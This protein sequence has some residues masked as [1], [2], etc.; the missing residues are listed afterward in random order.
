MLIL[1]NLNFKNKNLKNLC[2]VY[3]LK[4]YSQNNKCELLCKLNE[5]KA[6]IYIQQFFRKKKYEEY[7]CPITLDKLKYPFISI[8]KSNNSFC[9]YSLE[10]FVEYLNKSNNLIDPISRELLSD[11]TISN[12]EYLVKH[13][14]IKKKFNNRSWKKKIDLRAEYLTLTSCLNDVFNQIFSLDDLTL[15]FIYED[16]I[17]Q[18]IYYFNFLLDKH[19]NNCYSLIKHYINCLNHHKS[20]NKN[21]IIYYL[22]IIISI[23]NL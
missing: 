10:A 17:P 16:V 9:Y 13:Y 15:E 23:N 18:F 21:Y 7:I 5:Y 3:N 12:I 19:K 11:N 14:K 1:Y 8:K 20:N 2:K 4:N 6:T 22:S